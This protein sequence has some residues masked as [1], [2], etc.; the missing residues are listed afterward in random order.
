MTGPAKPA[1]GHELREHARREVM[2]SGRIECCGQQAPC[3]VVNLSAGGARVRTAGDYR[4]GQ[5]LCLD[6]EP[7]GK[8]TA[9]CAWVRGGEAGLTFTCDPAEVAEV[10][11]GLAMYG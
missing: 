5:E 11:I 1:P 9:T 3:E 4:P 8:F 2:L 7:C 10:L 6:I